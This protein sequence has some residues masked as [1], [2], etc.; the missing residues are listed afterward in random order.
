MSAPCRVAARVGGAAVK[1][2]HRPCQAFAWVADWRLRWYLR[3]GNWPPAGIEREVSRR[4]GGRKV[5]V[6]ACLL[7]VLTLGACVRQPLIETR[8]VEVPV[9]VATPIPPA[10]V[11]DCPPEASLPAEGPLYAADVLV[12]LRGV[13]AALTCARARLTAL[14][15]LEAGD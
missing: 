12:Y 4:C 11:A 2:P 7:L 9:P 8:T 15:E 10:L 6:A 3:T 5:S 14:R 1:P 13:E